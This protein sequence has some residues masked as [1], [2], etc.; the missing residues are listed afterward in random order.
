MEDQTPAEPMLHSS[1]TGTTSSSFHLNGFGVDAAAGESKRWLQ[2]L[3]K[4]IRAIVSIRLL[5]VRA[6][7]GN[8]A[9]FSVATGF[10]VD[11]ERGIILTN[12]HVVTPGPVVAD[13][14]FLNKE[15][16][17]LVPIYRDPVHDFGFFRFDPKKVKFLQLHEIPLRPEAAKIGAEIRVVGNDAGEKLSILP[18]ILAKLDRDAPSYGSGSYNDFNTFYFAAASSTSGGSSGSPVLNIDGCAI[19]LNAGGA[20]K[21]ASSFYL[22][23]DRVVRVL[24]LIQ[25]GQPVP[26]GTIQTIFRHTAFDE[27]RRL[28]LSGDTE[29][30]V[31]QQYPQ[32]TGM[33]VVDQVIQGGP[34]HD[35]L[36]TGDVLIQ[37]AGQYGATFL[38]IEDFLDSHVGQTVEAQFQRGDEQYTTTLSIQDL[39]SITPDRYLEIGGGIVH[40]LSYQQARNAS[41]PVGGVYLAQAGHM[42]MKAHLA[43]PCIITSVAGQPTPTLDDFARVMASLPNG[44]RT[45]LRY[46]MIRDRHRVRT[47][48]IMMD[49][50]W[51]PM[52]MCTRNDEDGLW[53]SK[54]YIQDATSGDNSSLV[55]TANSNPTFAPAPLSFPG[56]N[57]LGK[58]TLLSLVMVSFD[59]PYMIDGISSSSYHGMGVVIDAEQ[60]F[61]LVDQNTVPI[62]LGDVLITIAAT[63]EVPAKVVFVHPVHN[64]SIVQY[65]PKA[66][67]VVAE[68]IKSV[69]LA[70]KLLEVGETAD[71]IGLSSNWTVVTMKSVVTKLDRLVLRDFQ[72]PRYKACNIEVLHFDRITKSVGGVFIDDAG[73]V[74]ALWLSFSYQDNAGRKEVFRGLPIS[75]VRPIVDELR[76]S[77]IPNSVNIL[78]AQLL[79]YSLSKARSGLG[80]SDEWIQKLGSCYEDKRQV[81]GIKRCAAG[82]DCAGKLESG[83]LL[84]AIDGQVVVR[85]ADVEN[86]VD[87]KTELKAL[88]VRDQKEVEVTVST[89]QLSAMGTDRVIVWCGLVIQSPH[90]AVASLGYIPEEGGGVYCSRWCYGSPAHKYGLRATIWLVEVNGEPTR[91]LDDFL[92]VVERLGNRESVRLK[93]ISINTKPKVFTLKTDYHYWPTVELRREEWDW[94][95]VE[96]PVVA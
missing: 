8:G 73:A 90:Y 76:A 38:K 20:K 59:I 85:D 95:Y 49:R 58:K 67:G 24:G 26:R 61:V 87:G 23:L 36:R 16:V 78:P 50:L 4:C 39:H 35:K 53:Y 60:G 34:A 1:N 43:Q 42:F 12:R 40:A 27:V 5:S 82:T 77:R 19:A 52:Q 33:L 45:V 70:D 65:D 80:L 30:L 31:R 6:F 44:L 7:D 96:H 37:F 51:F 3:E 48:F 57:A 69:V 14:I 55:N 92:R 11:M 91:T 13:A 25:Q 75:I 62:A 88:V 2:S 22:P 94:K 68:H 41:L 15:E 81:L 10:V 47:A 32:E 17:D 21:A 9:S 28:G 46:F 86:A 74:N 83:D 72:P 64:F 56:G 84:L 79:T 18:G 93:T 89:S 66:L 63:V 29:A 54:S 71:Y